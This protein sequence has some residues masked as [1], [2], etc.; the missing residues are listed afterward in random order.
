MNKTD[1]NIELAVNEHEIKE[2]YTHKHKE[3]PKIFY[4][5]MTLL[6]GSVILFFAHI[7]DTVSYIALVIGA[8]SLL[9]LIFTPGAADKQ[10]REPGSGFGSYVIGLSGKYPSCAGKNLESY[11]A[12]KFRLRDDD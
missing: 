9:V 6:L 4:V 1:R 3:K 8:I 11:A 10:S 12:G 2:T 5:S 7:N